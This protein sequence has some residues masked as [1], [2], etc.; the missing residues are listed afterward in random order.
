MHLPPVLTDTVHP[1][2]AQT[3]DQAVT[4]LIEHR[5]RRHRIGIRTSQTTINH[6][7]GPALLTAPGL[8]GHLRVFKQSFRPGNPPQMTRHFGQPGFGKR[9]APCRR[10]DIVPQGGQ[11]D[12]HVVLILTKK[13]YHPRVII[14]LIQAVLKRILHRIPDFQQTVT[15]APFRRCRLNGI[16][17]PDRHPVIKQQALLLIQKFHPGQV[18]NKR[19]IRV[20]N[21]L[22][23]RPGHFPRTGKRLTG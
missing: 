9:R 10:Q 14:M 12:A 23:I 8:P 2:T 11:R 18:I 17:R 22:L 19:R 3:A 6:H 21:L 20:V 15:G 13:L 16:H 4:H 1:G 5:H 7:P